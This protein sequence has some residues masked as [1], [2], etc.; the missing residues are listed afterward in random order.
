MDDLAKVR[1]AGVVVCSVV[2]AGFGAVAYS[3]WVEWGET[4]GGTVCGD[5]EG[6]YEWEVAQHGLWMAAVA[7]LLWVV[8]QP[9][10][11]RFLLVSLYLLG[12]ALLTCT[13]TA[14][15]SFS[16]FTA[17]CT[18][19][20]DRC[21]LLP[22]YQGASLVYGHM[23]VSLLM[24]ALLSLALLCVL[25]GVVWTY[26]DQKIQESV[27]RIRAPAYSLIV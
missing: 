21:T 11:Y 22:S 19:V 6:L 7:V 12:P 18:S 16:S 14:L 24:A 27:R 1:A 26:L 25:A 5:W 9:G 3:Y 23:L 13:I 20:Q 10:K 4:R 17:C 8:V 2:L 15:I